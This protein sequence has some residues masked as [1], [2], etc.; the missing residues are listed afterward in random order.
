M[1]TFTL[2]PRCWQIPVP[3]ALTHSSRAKTMFS[4][5]PYT[6]NLVLFLRKILVPALK[7]KMTVFPDFESDG[8]LISEIKIPVFSPPRI[9][10]C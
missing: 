8:L 5:I 9:G 7:M 10:L 2:L 1:W 3:T 6:E 4:K